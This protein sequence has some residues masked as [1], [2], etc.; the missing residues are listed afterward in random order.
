MERVGGIVGLVFGR[1]VRKMG[2]TRRHMAHRFRRW[3]SAARSAH[4]IDG[5]NFGFDVAHDAGSDIIFGSAKARGLPQPA[6]DLPGAKV[7]S[8]ARLVLLLKRQ[9]VA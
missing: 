1:L 9:F 3:Y 4:P 2:F 7:R 6:L 8:I 5:D